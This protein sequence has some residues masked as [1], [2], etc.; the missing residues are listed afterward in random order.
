M[1]WTIS[2]LFL[3]K[4]ETEGLQIEKKNIAILNYSNNGT[5]NKE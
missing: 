1:Q 2:E 4:S 3:D 5:L